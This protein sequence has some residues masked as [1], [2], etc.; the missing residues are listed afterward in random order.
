MK[1]VDKLIAYATAVGYMG[2]IKGLLIYKFK[3]HGAIPTQLSEEIWKR[4]MNCV[5]S[6]KWQYCRKNRTKMQGTKDAATDD[7][8]SAIFALSIWS[9]NVANAEFLNFFQSMVM[10]CGR[11]SEMG[12]TRFQH[13]SMKS[14]EE[15]SGK[16]YETLGQYI[17]RMKTESKIILILSPTYITF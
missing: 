7:D 15:P 9:G 14:I 12:L 17:E 5:R 1:G 4:Y 11:G 13:F 2:S 10:N 3:N 8:R 6:Q 16:T